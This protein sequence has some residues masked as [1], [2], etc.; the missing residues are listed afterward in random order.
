MKTIYLKLQTWFD[1]NLVQIKPDFLTLGYRYVIT[2][3]EGF[4]PLCNNEE[5][6]DKFPFKGKTSFIYD[7]H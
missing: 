1:V 5:T 7:A 3:S 4:T 6:K 2:S